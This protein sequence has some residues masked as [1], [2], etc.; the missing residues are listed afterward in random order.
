MELEGQLWLVDIS[1][2]MEKKNGELF[3]LHQEAKFDTH[4]PA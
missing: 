4:V 3:G 2:K 1:E